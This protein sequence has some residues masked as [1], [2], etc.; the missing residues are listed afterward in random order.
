MP[1]TLW[2]CSTPRAPPL[3]EC[4]SWGPRPDSAALR[5]QSG[6]SAHGLALVHELTWGSPSPLPW[7]LGGRLLHTI[8]S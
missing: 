1:H 4:R 3:R 7:T 5:S 6:Q 8:T 2:N